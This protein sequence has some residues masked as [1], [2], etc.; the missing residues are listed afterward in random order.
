M[1][2]I[3]TSTAVPDKF[4]PGLN[5]FKGQLPLN[6]PPTQLSA[7]WFD[8][9]QMEIVYV[10]LGQ[11]IAL[12]GLQFDQLKQAIDNYTFADPKIAGSLI[13]Q[14]GA[15]LIVNDG[16]LLQCDPG[17]IASIDTLGANVANIEALNVAVCE[18]S[19]GITG[20]NATTAIQ[21]FGVIEAAILQ[22]TA[23]GRVSTRRLE[24]SSSA[25]AVANMITRRSD[26]ALAWGTVD[27]IHASPAGWVHRAAH[28]DSAGMLAAHTL[29]TS[30][31]TAPADGASTLRIVGE[32]MVRRSAAGSC[33]CSI[34]REDSPGAGTYTTIGSS[35]VLVISS[36]A[37]DFTHV[38][39][40]RTYAPGFSSLRYRLRIDADG[41]GSCEIESADVT[42]DQL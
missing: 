34:Q 8:S 35:R 38:R 22:T 37:N 29:T 18:V 13:I 4:G 24:L 23:P 9:V 32:A 27:T 39:I 42:V 15:A 41:G 6:A 28:S 25:T 33:T 30:S 5:G 16:G 26:G 14:N 36:A 12:D 7:E 31:G 21:G 1:Q 17:S 11:G 20:V 2:V 3:Q 10:L 19:A 40:S